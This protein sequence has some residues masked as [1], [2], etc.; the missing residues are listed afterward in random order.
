MTQKKKV[1][2]VLSSGGVLCFSYIGAYRKLLETYDI[3]SVSACSMGSIL[4]VLICSGK[5]PDEIEQAVLGF[6]F[7]LLKTK[8][9]FA[10]IR[11]LLYPFASHH[12]PDFP[13]IIT[14]LIGGDLELGVLQTPFSVAALDIRQNKFLVYASGTHPHMNISEVVRIATAIPFMY[15]PV[16]IGGRLLVDAAVACESPVWMASG[17]PDKYPIVVLKPEKPRN[18]TPRRSLPSFLVN[19][20][21]ASTGSH[22]QFALSQTPRTVEININCGNLRYDNFKIGREEIEGLVQ[23]GYDE[24]TRVLKEYRNDFGRAM[25]VE[26]IRGNGNGIQQTDK[27][28]DADNAELLAGKMMMDS[29]SAGLQRNQVFISYCHDDREWL[30]ELQVHL[31]AFQRFTGLKVWDDTNIKPGDEWDLE[32]R[33]ALIATKVAVFLVTP[34]FLASEF[35]QEREMKY[36]LDISKAEKVPILWVAVKPS[37]YR[38]TPLNAIQC[39][40]D[41]EQPLSTLE[42][43][44][45]E[46]VKICTAIAAQMKAGY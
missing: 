3:A 42:D 5:S 45:N 35:I 18:F 34:E 38:N 32:I 24:T 19:I 2:L 40:N 13:S 6:D 11:Q 7:S 23:E 14:G 30:E 27:A 4:G 21:A 28:A 36:F 25:E 41:P 9:L 17:K 37:A 39:A 46:W 15:E 31:S 22:D 12:V 1:H 16:K 44:D 43:T 10:K 33:K 8:K 26:M 20:F 29:Q